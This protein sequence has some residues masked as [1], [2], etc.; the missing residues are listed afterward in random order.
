MSQV[1]GT[2]VYWKWKPDNAHGGFPFVSFQTEA[3]VMRYQL[4]AYDWS[5]V[6]GAADPGVL[7]NAATGLPAVLSA[8]TVTDWGFYSQVLYG[9]SK[10][11]VVGLRGDYVTG[12]LGSY[13]QL[14]LTLDGT[15]VGRDQLRRERWR[16]APNLTWYPSEF[17]KIRLQ[18]NY[19]SRA[20][21]GVDSSVWLQ[22]EFLLGSHAA[23]KF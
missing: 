7:V 4:G 14:P 23:H 9:F 2:D 18:Y 22:F 3:M 1:Y 16:L 11:W 8:E 21:L 20:D 13:E 10:G 15:P 5:V 19:D 17:S 6:G 12:S